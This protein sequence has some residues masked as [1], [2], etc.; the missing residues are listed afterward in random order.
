LLGSEEAMA[1]KAV[2]LCQQRRSNYIAPHYYRSQWTDFQD[3]LEPSGVLQKASL[4]GVQ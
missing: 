3:Y 1:L 2:V 4:A